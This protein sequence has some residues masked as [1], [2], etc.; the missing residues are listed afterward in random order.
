[1][2]GMDFCKVPALCIGEQTATEAR[3]YHMKIEIS[4]RATIASMVEKLKE[5]RAKQEV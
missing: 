4:D 5:L 3:K 1:M 2:G